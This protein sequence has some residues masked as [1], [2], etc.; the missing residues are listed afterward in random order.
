[1]GLEVADGLTLAENGVFGPSSST[2]NAVVRFDGTSG[3]SIQNSGVIIDDSN[4]I[5]SATISVSSATPSA[6]GLY[7]P[8]ANTLGFS[9]NSLPFLQGTVST[10]AVNWATINGGATGGGV[11]VGSSGSDTDVSINVRPKGAGNYTY[12]TTTGAMQ[13]QRYTADVNGCIFNFDKSRNASVGNQTIVQ[14]GD[15]LG[16]VRFRGSDGANFVIAA[17]IQ[18]LVDGT[19]GTNDMP[20]SLS[21]STTADGASSVTERMRINSTGAV[22]LPT[23]GTTASAANCFINNASSPVNSIL[24]VTSSIRYKTDVLD[25]TDEE[26]NGVLLLRPITYKSIADADDKE[27]RYF[28]F[29]AEEVEQIEPKLVQWTIDANGNKIPD[30]VQ[31]ERV[32]VCLLKLVQD[33]TKRVEDLEGK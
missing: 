10:S 8:A 19:P 5:S 6:N 2:D 31:Y 20:G 11:I 17:Q 13:A 7:L 3:N 28:G 4:N 30:G 22:F 32:V 18:A 29:I 12:Q 25:I 16:N 15:A 26:A 23:I 1:M 33:L 14:N 24:R 27:D 21:F 9:A